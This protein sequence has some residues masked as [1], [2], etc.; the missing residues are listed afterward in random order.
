MLE[1]ISDLKI[2]YEC[3]RGLLKKLWRVT[4]GPRAADCPSLA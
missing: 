4:C 3:S 2:F 1:E